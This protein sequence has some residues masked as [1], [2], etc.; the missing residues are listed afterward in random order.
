[1]FRPYR[2]ASPKREMRQLRGS[3]DEIISPSYYRGTTYSED[4]I[5]VILTDEDDIPN[6][7][8]RLRAVYPY[9]MRLDYD[10]TR[11]RADIQLDV[12]VERKSPLELFADFFR[13]QNNRELTQEQSEFVARLLDRIEEGDR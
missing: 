4:Y 9:L 10:N 1:M 5:R 3:F 7:V 13:L 2:S 11:T 12:A 8:G 6:A